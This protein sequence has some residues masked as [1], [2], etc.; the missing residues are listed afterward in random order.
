MTVL[1]SSNLN[2]VLCS[3]NGTMKTNKTP[4]KDHQVPSLFLHLRSLSSQIRGRGRGAEG[5]GG[6]QQHRWEGT[7]GFNLT[8]PEPPN[9][10]SLW[11]SR[12]PVQSS[13]EPSATVGPSSTLG[14]RKPH[15]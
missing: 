8:L 6:R 4:N 2:N 5:A 12:K 13:S 11:F 10:L 3:Q 15:K 14:K 7:Q 9:H 1:S